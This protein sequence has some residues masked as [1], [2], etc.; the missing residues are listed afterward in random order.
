M[1]GHEL[2]EAL[3]LL[4]Q[5][6]KRAGILAMTLGLFG[7][8]F[9]GYDVMK[10]APNKPP[11]RALR[12]LAVALALLAGGRGRRQPHGERAHYKGYTDR[13]Q[14]K[15]FVHKHLRD[16]KSNQKMPMKFS[17]SWS[18]F[19][20]RYASR[21]ASVRIGS[22][23]LIHSLKTLFGSALTLRGFSSGVCV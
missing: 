6:P 1:F 3:K 7:L 13:N 16:W 18:V 9:D 8:L 2:V 21:S 4:K 12:P 20:S 5:C 10:T 17:R 11:G 14:D 23:S 22:T 15:F 19:N